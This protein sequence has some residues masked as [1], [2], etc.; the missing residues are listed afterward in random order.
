MATL[1]LTRFNYGPELPSPVGG[2]FGTI[3]LPSGRKLY[4]VEPPWVR[5]K[6]SVSC[7]PEGVYK[8]RMR[9]SGVVS[10][11]SGGEFKSGWEITEVPNRTFIMLHPGNWPDNF[12]GC[13]GFGLKYGMLG[14]KLA[15]FNSRDAFRMMMSEFPKDECHEVHILPYLVEYP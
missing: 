15:V 1:R 2:T 10:R 3:E 13:I 8:L 9:D 11:S 14:D 12:E 7:I 5:N 6:Q 4:T